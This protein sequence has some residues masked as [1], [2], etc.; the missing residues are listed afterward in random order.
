MQDKKY[1]KVRDRCHY[2]G[3]YRGTAESICNLKYGIPKKIPIIFHN[4]SDY[5][6]CFIIKK[7]AEE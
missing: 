4:G 3:K 1:H 7:L 5:D 6:Y 2:T